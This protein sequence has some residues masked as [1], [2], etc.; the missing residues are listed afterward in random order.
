LQSPLGQRL[1]L[2]GILARLRL[3]S[4]VTLTPEG[5]TAEEQ[6]RLIDAMLARG[7]RSFM[8]HYHSPSLGKQTPYVRTDADLAT[9]LNRIEAVCRH[10]FQRRGGL[11]GHPAD[12]LPQDMRS[13]LWP[14]A[15]T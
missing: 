8:L 14:A 10:F 12:L 1:R 3:A 9:F 2:R 11:P 13:R 5:V 4:T 6:V 15:G 7:C